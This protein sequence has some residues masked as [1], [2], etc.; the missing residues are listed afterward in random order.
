MVYPSPETTGDT[1]AAAPSAPPEASLR[2]FREPD[3]SAWLWLLIDK[4]KRATSRKLKGSIAETVV[5]R[6]VEPRAWFRTNQADGAVIKV[7]P[8]RTTLERLKAKFAQMRI[9]VS[10]NSVKSRAASWRFISTIA[11]P[12]TSH[13]SSSAVFG[14]PPILHMLCYVS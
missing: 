5:L 8:S 12:H 9:N 3:C 13:S 1:A 2:Y 10:R 4:E 7:D 14:T 11:S 6:G